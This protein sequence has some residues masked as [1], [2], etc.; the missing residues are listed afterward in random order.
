MNACEK[1]A[2]EGLAKRLN[3]A[4]ERPPT[5]EDYHEQFNI[6]LKAL[7]SLEH[8]TLVLSP[9]L[10]VLLAQHLPLDPLIEDESAKSQ[11]EL[12]PWTSN[13]H[14]TMAQQI[15]GRLV[16]SHAVAEEADQEGMNKVTLLLIKEDRRLL[17][18]SLQLLQS[19]LQ[20]VINHPPAP[21]CLAWITSKLPHPH[22]GKA[23]PALIPHV[24]RCLDCWLTRPRVLGA[25]IA[26]HLATTCPPAELA[27]YGRT[28]LL[29]AA[30]L[31]LLSQDLSCLKDASPPLLELTSHL[32]N[33]AK[34]VPS[35]PGPA[36]HLLA[37]VIELI[38]LN[39][40]GKERRD[41]LCNLLVS[42]SDLLGIGVARWV[43]SL[44]SL[45]AAHSSST[46]LID[47]IP[48]LCKTCPEAMAREMKTLLPA[49]IKH[50]Y[51][52]SWEDPT[53]PGNISEFKNSN[54]HTALCALAATDLDQAKDLCH[55]LRA[56]PVNPTF[57]ALV[58][59]LEMC[60]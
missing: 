42:V 8:V 23:T 21:H 54:L 1:I 51:H 40:E 53:E 18:R 11:D 48:L 14:H 55:G 28:E 58:S 32:Q 22:L 38:E 45:M 36:D 6:S 41:L 9:H 33:S 49:L 59:K 4:E 60:T 24:L 37:R 34:G 31:P 3:L 13:R 47:H 25:R 5:V 44:S 27:W 56:V 39:T 19:E 17:T 29:H 52:L 35:L 16:S 26:N 30:L 46:H 57:D 50:A 10:L 2:R 20:E 15:L 12:T 7:E 43:T